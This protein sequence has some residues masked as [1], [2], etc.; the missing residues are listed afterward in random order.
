LKNEIERL[1]SEI[2]E[3]GRRK[4]NN[5]NLFPVGA[6]RDEEDKIY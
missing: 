6:N 3:I 5:I 1:K 2:R 4:L